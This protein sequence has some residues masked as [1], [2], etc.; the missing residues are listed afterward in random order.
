MLVISLKNYEP[1]QKEFGT[2]WSYLDI[3]KFAF[4]ELINA[5]EDYVKSL[6]GMTDKTKAKNIFIS[7]LDKFYNTIMAGFN[8]SLQDET[9]WLERF[10]KKLS[11]AHFDEL[12]DKELISMFKMLTNWSQREGPFKTQNEK[13][14]WSTVW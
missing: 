11:F 3:I 8:D 14:D 9:E 2:D 4:A 5:K 10:D 7:K 13:Q 6:T 1:M 12:D